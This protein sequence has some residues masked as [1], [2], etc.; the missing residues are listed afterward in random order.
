MSNAILERIHQV[1]GNLVRTSNIQQTYV[2]KNDPWMGILAAAAFAICS[3]I[4]GQKGYSPGQLIFGHDMIFPIKHRVDSELIRQQKQ[5]KILEKT[6]AR[7]NI[8]LNMT[9]KLEIKSCSLTTMD[10]NTYR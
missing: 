3:T 5:T 9:I 10:T 2:D 7:I 8:E 1:L 4:S 6:P